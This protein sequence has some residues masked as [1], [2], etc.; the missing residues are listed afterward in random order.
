MP[1]I[2]KFTSSQTPVTAG[3]HIVYFG[4]ALLI[5]IGAAFAAQGFVAFVG[6]LS[7]QLSML[8]TPVP[9]G[10]GVGFIGGSA[11]LKLAGMLF[12]AGVLVMVILFWSGQKKF[13][14][15][16]DTI[17]A[18][19]RP[20][21]QVDVKEGIVSTLVAAISM[22]GGAPVGQ[23][24]PLVHFGATLAA[25]VSKL[26]KLPR[27]AS[28]TLLAC[29]VAGAISA[30]FG[31]PLA[32]IL[33][34]HEAILR[35]FSL[36]V[37]APVTIS[38][39]MAYAVVNNFFTIPDLLPSLNIQL[40]DLNELLLLVII[41]LG[42][43]VVASAFMA[44][45]L[46]TERATLKLPVPFWTLPLVAASLLLVVGMFVPQILGSRPDVLIAAINGEIIITS[47]LV[48]GL[49]KLLMAALSIAFG[50]YAGVFAPALFI[51]VMFGATIGQMAFSVGVIE[52]NS[53][54]LFAIAG[55]GA[56]ISSTIGA[57]LTTI[58][59]VLELTSDYGTMTGVMISVVFSNMVSTRLFGRSL[60]D[61][62]LLAR[63]LD[64]SLSRNDYKLAQAKLGEL[65]LADYCRLNSSESAEEKI[66]TLITNDC[67]EGYVVDN[68]GNFVN[69]HD[70]IGLLQGREPKPC[71]IL[72]D[73]MSVPEVMK[74]LSSFVGE[75]LPVTDVN[76]KML[77][78]VTE[79]R[80]FDFYQTIAVQSHAE[81][82]S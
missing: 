1:K 12:G 73:D 53:L 45:C 10:Y 31:A 72:T 78:I 52:V 56:V 23:Y 3:S 32:G 49:L 5:G 14:G 40:T 36:R 21:A 62:K 43:G 61:R 4:L 50:L 75:S 8:G 37:F 30:A 13:Y 27:P 51:G 63:G 26:A 76:G 71:I 9:H 28:E 77:G 74:K 64:I 79:S 59:I 67:S 65:V 66:K 57:P 39:A 69:R 70:L 33:F 35:H 15:P 20:T 55:M 80:I 42:G 7:L 38:A 41:G 24:G 81:E 2:S 34:A 47:L 60:F 44:F 58:L 18:A 29:G 19:R 17:E 68:Q 11:S 16:S 22:G 48:F 54:G 6:W 25:I 46:K 82:D